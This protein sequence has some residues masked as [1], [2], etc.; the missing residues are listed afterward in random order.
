MTV[1][2][3]VNVDS[4]PQALRDLPRWVL[5]RLVTKPGAGKPTKVPYQ[6]LD[7]QAQAESDNPA[8]WATFDDAWAAVQADPEAFAGIGIMLGDGL[9]GVDLDDC[10]DT[11]TGDVDTE[12]LDIIGHFATY[13][14][15]SPSGRG[16]KLFLI[17]TLPSDRGRKFENMWVSK[18]GRVELYDHGRFFAVTGNAWPDAP[19]VVNDRDAKFKALFQRLEARRQAGRK[20]N[21]HAIPATPGDVPMDV[22]ADRCRK[23]IERMPDAISGQRGHDRTLQ[24]A[25]ETVRFGLDDSAT[26]DVLRWFNDRKTGGER[27]TD[28]ELA[29]KIRSAQDLAGSERGIR[30]NDDRPRKV[31]GHARVAPAAANDG[32]DGNGSEVPEHGQ[33]SPSDFPLTDAGNGE[34]LMHRHGDKLLHIALWKKWAVYDGKRWRVDETG[35]ADRLALETIRDVKQQGADLAKGEDDERHA[36]GLRMVKWAHKCES[37]GKVTAMLHRAAAVKGATILPDRLDTD[38]WAFNCANGTLELRTGELRPNRREDLITKLS[39][40]RYDPS[41]TCPDFLR[42]LDTTFESNGRLIAFVKRMVGYCLTGDTSE[43]AIFIL[44]GCGANGKSTLLAV[45]RELLGPYAAQVGADALMIKKNEGI[46]NDLAKLKGS[47]VVSAVESDEG[48]HLAEGLVKNMSGGTDTIAAR[49]L[50]GEEFE[51][52]P[53]YKLFLATNHPPI[54]RGTDSG[55][56]D[57]IKMIPFNARF[58][59]TAREAEDACRDPARVKDKRLLDKLRAELDGILA[60]AVQGCLEWQRDGLGVPE[61]VQKATSGYRDNM[62]RLADFIADCCIV[63]PGVKAGASEMYATYKIWAALNSEDVM[64]QTK[65][66]RQLESKGFGSDRD[67]VTGRKNRIG[68]GIK[69]SSEQLNGSEQS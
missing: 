55:I 60:W 59:D 56:W 46:R 6:A 39:P 34:R 66:G 58:Y 32:N 68:I 10:I 23:Y 13:T 31:N 15:I 37:D 63:A 11:E 50:Y 7:P 44:H 51:Y 41:L 43:R 14:E 18:A 35:A 24:A 8:T 2:P 62:D 40:V 61:E 38:R 17:G 4:I 5:W 19:S 33:I 49:F 36:I 69:A 47:R 1:A 26:W 12:A 52:V 65:F 64:S 28:H 25:C 22:R 48:R 3:A 27:W 54:V 67:S 57:R 16:V 20:T 53:E 29:H 21:G 45:L 9:A 30:L 42:F